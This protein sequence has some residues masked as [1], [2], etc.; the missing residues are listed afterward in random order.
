VVL[1]A[2]VG[3]NAEVFLQV[4]ALHVPLGA[5]VADVT[6]GK[7]VF[8]QGVPEGAYEVL[9]TDLQSGVDATD[10][11]YEQLSPGPRTPSRNIVP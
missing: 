3:G 7:G 8:W 11:L 1:S 4:L 9:A 10:L 2:T 5:R 6:W